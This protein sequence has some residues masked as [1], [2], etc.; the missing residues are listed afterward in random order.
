M[1]TI[2]S[3]FILLSLYSCDKIDGDRYENK[4]PVIV[5]TTIEVE[6][7]GA[8]MF[9]LEDLGA[10]NSIYGSGVTITLAGETIG[11]LQSIPI[12]IPDCGSW[13]GI[14][15]TKTEGNYSYFATVIG[16]STTWSGQ[17]VIQKNQ[18][19]KVPL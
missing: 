14:T 7:T 19:L 8:V 18:C 4:P 2:L 5:D 13:W 15:K 10:N 11:T 9:Y 16:G 12:G 3:F 1:K 17:I 6:Q